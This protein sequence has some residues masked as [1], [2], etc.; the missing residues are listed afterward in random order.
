MEYY[1][2]YKI[3]DLYLYTTKN[4]KKINKIVYIVIILVKKFIYNNITTLLYTVVIDLINN[5]S[6][7]IY[8]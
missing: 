2:N 5:Y 6:R 7:Y 1:I 8:K 4:I 3:I